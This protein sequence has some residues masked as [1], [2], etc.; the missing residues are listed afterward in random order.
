MN[1]A[2]LVQ[3]NPI[4]VVYLLCYFTTASL[5]RQGEDLST[6]TNYI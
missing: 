4:D 2:G 1:T 6:N 3:K 5:V